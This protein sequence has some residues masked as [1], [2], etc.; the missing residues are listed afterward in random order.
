MT[1]NNTFS[2]T[3]L[4]RGVEAGHAEMDAL[5]EEERAGTGVVKLFPVVALNCLDS[6]AK[7]V[8]A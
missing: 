7:L 8:L 5:G 4:R 6:G 1:A 3:V 2:F